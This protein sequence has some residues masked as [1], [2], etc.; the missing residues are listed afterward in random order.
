M[1]FN[2][3]KN[4]V[5]IGLSEKETNPK[6]NLITKGSKPINASRTPFVKDEERCPSTE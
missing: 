1:M 6:L 5:K 4:N 3:R 2:Y